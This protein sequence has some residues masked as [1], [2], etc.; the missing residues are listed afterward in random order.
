LL[1]RNFSSQGCQPAAWSIFCWRKYEDRALHQ[2]IC[3]NAAERSRRTTSMEQ[4]QSWHH[5][6]HR[7]WTIQ[8]STFLKTFSIILH[9]IFPFKKQERVCKI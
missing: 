2:R 5:H 1:P 8:V 6:T 9:S 7:D 3:C 4:H